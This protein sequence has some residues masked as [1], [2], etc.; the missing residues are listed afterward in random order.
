MA[1]GASVKEAMECLHKEGIFPCCQTVWRFK[2]HYN[3]DQNE[4][5]EPL[6]SSGQPTKLTDEVL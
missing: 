1:Q 6:W 2:R 4:S 5:I 3:Y